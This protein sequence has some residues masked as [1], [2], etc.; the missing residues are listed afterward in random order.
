[1][2]NYICNISNLLLI[3]NCY[4]YKDMK[5]F[6]SSE[7]IYPFGNYFY[8]MIPGKGVIHIYENVVFTQATCNDVILHMTHMFY[9]NKH[10][11][12]FGLT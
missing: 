5:Y 11:I 9:V 12:I 7:K 3:L 1:M 10:K 2:T 4:S 8:D 6:C